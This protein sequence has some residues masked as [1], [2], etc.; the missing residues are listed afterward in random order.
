MENVEQLLAAK[1]LETFTVSGIAETFLAAD[2]MAWNAIEKV[3][4]GDR[5]SAWTLKAMGHTFV[6]LKDD[7]SGVEF[8]AEFVRNPDEEDG[9]S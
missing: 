2:V 4:G 8:H 6:A 1:R 9:E 3:L 7:A 5:I